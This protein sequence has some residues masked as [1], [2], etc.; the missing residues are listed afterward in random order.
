MWQ[1]QWDFKIKVIRRLGISTEAHSLCEEALGAVTG[2]CWEGEEENESCHTQLVQLS[3]TAFALAEAQT[4][5]RAE[6]AQLKSHI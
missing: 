6:Q 4:A 3:D 5:Y 1:E 2:T